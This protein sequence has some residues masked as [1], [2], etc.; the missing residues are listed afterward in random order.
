MASHPETASPATLRGNYVLLRAD[1][2]RLLLP[3]HEVG[4]ADYLEG[5]LEDAEMTGLLQYA[6]HQEQRRFAA[7]SARMTLLPACPADRF[8]V[9]SLGAADDLGWCWD[10]VKILIDV[11][12][13]PQLLPTVLIAPNTPVDR[14][15]EHDGEI[16]FLCSAQRVLTYALA[17]RN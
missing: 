15:V 2:L 16:A 8:V 6:D 4:A 17:P 1:T 12:L 14:F 5:T 7:L 13:H 10:E 11:E 9:T 3:Q